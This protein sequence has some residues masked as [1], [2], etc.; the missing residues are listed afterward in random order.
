LNFDRYGRHSNTFGGASLSHA[1]SIATLDVIEEEKLLE[2]ATTLGAKAK[3]RLIEM[4]EEYDIIG[5]TRGLGMMLAHE[6]VQDR[7]TKKHASKS[8]DRIT[9]IA[10]KKGLML[11]PCG[12][13]VTRYIPPLNIPEEQLDKGMEILD[14]CIKIVNKDRAD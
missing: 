3:K 4:Q 12:R 7:K 14:E 1:A 10:F 13:S 11:L 5:D 9:E 6:F 2:R 8:R